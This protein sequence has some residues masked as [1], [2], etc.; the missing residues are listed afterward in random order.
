MIDTAGV[1]PTQRNSAA[2]AFFESKHASAQADTAETEPQRGTAHD[3]RPRC[4]PRFDEK[5][6]LTK[7][8]RLTH[9]RV[10][11]LRNGSPMILI[12]DH[13]LTAKGLSAQACACVS[14][15]KKSKKQSLI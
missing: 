5:C 11:P 15:A 6:L 10:A 8:S 14:V 12:T 2:N 3:S 4:K 1:P 13:M 9:Y 7:H